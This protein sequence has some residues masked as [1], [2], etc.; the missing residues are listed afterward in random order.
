LRHAEQAAVAGLTLVALVCMAA[1]WLL[2]GGFRG[3]LIDI[4]R[5]D[6]LEARF[7]VDINEAQWPELA[8]LPDIGETLARR[9][10]ES[11]DAQGPFLDH[12]QLQRVQG[13]GPVTVER[14]RPYLL[15]L[16]DQ[17]EIA[18]R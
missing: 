15:P 2:Q 8:Q 9:I 16:P 10:V 17:S 1:Y 13:I 12:D 11:R 3:E 4:D 18:G 7:R 6:P 5:A 14:I